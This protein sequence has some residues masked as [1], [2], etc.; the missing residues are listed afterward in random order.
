MAWYRANRFH[1]LELFV[2]AMATIAAVREWRGAGGESERRRIG[3]VTNGPA[4]V[5]REKIGLLGV[6]RVVDFALVS[7]EL[8]IWK[9]DPGIFV[10]ALRLGGAAPEEALFVGDSA[11]FDIAGAQAVGMRTVWVNRSERPWTVGRPPDR[12][13]GALAELVPML[14]S[15]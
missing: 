4:E 13:I 2:D 8:G 5:Q 10:E 6:D 14:R 7:G 9:P 12:E 15:D 1:G 3:L 11:E